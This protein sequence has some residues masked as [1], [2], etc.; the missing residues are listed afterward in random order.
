M[1]LRLIVNAM[2]VLDGV[3]VDLFDD[4]DNLLTAPV[5][6]LKLNALG[7]EM[8]LTREGTLSFNHVDAMV[9]TLK[10]LCDFYAA[11]VPDADYVGFVNHSSPNLIPTRSILG[12]VMGDPQ[13]VPVW[14]VSSHIN[15]VQFFNHGPTWA[16][17]DAT[18][19]YNHAVIFDPT[20][21][22]IEHLYHPTDAGV[23]LRV[24]GDDDKSYELVFKGP[25]L[26]LADARMHGNPLPIEDFQ[27]SSRHN[28]FK[29]LRAGDLLSSNC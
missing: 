26:I 5:G 16:A 13:D 12:A 25:S 7:K 19:R 22:G 4:S 8:Y 20:S 21:V 24:V 15:K 17:L 10:E 18:G 14:F 1:K 6:R 28:I 23:H 11:I 9:G 3:Q 2:N 27:L 29:V